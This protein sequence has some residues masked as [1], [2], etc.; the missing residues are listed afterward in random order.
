MLDPALEALVHDNN[1]AS[2]T[3]LA[4]GGEPQTSVMWIDCDHEHLFI[5]TEIARAK[6]RNISQNPHVSV[7]VWERENP[8]HYVEVRGLVTATTLGDRAND[9]LE[10]LARRYTG[11]AFAGTIESARVIVEITPTR[12]RV[13][14]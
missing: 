10:E 13:V 6:F 11:Q 1:F 14:D 5:N 12:T 2:L 7:L 9:H 8:Y 4:P 3:T